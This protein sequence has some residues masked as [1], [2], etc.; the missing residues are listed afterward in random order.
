MPTEP[1]AISVACDVA[2]VV[3]LLQAV[4]VLAV[5]VCVTS[6]ARKAAIPDIS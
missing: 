6:T 5:P 1:M 3:P 4:P 2:A